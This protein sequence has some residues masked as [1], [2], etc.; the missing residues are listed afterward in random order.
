[1]KIDENYE[2]GY[3]STMREDFKLYRC[4][5]LKEN[6]EYIIG[7][8]V[9]NAKTYY[10]KKSKETE[11]FKIGTDNSFYAVKEDSGLVFKKLILNVINYNNI[12]RMTM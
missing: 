5:F 9:F 4:I 1:M 10:I 6:K 12:V 11:T 3:I 2:R 8:D 7:K